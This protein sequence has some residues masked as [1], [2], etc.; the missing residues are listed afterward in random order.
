MPDLQSGERKQSLIK[1]GGEQ[2]IRTLGE[3]PHVCFQ[4]RGHKPLGQLSIDTKK[5]NVLSTSQ[6]ELSAIHT[7]HADD[8]KYLFSI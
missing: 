6:L 5:I 4:G 3:F 2:G 8:S 7:A 1:L